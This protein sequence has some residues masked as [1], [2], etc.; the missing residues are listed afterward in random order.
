MTGSSKPEASSTSELSNHVSQ[1][2]PFCL[3]NFEL[4]LLVHA[5][6]SILININGWP[7]NKSL[8]VNFIYF[9]EIQNK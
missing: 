6:E 8:C 3:S 7:F 9:D 2:L 1:I 4:E 5:S